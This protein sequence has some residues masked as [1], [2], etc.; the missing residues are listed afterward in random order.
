MI[1]GTI[2]RTNTNMK[3]S[4]K[5]IQHLYL[6]AGFGETPAYIRSK[7]TSDIGSLVDEL[8][9][10]SEKSVPLDFLPKPK[11][12]RKGEV[13]PLQIVALILRSQKENE[14]LNIAWLSRMTL[15]KGRLREKMTFFWQDHFACSAPFS[16][17]MQVQNNMLRE[18]AL[19]SFRKMLHAIARDPAM[20]IY[21]N[22]QQNKKARPNENFAREV[23]ELFTL[24]I[25]HYTE[26]D[27]KEAA[28]AFT[29]WSV[30]RSGNYKFE[31]NEH[32]D[33]EKTVFGKKG[34]FNGG[35]II[36]MLLEQKQ[37]ARYI[38]RKIYREFVSEFVNED[39]VEEMTRIF[40]ESDYNI[41]K[42]M[43]H[44]FTSEW[45]YADENIGCK[46]ASPVELIVRLVRL[47]ELEFTDE[48]SQ[49]E[50][51][52]VLGQTLFFPPNVAGWKGGRNWIDSSSLII[53]LSIPKAMI[54]GSA[55]NLN[56]KP[57]FEEL[58]EKKNKE[59]KVRA[60]WKKIVDQ[61]AV[62]PD[63][64]LEEELTA[65]LIQSPA[66]RIDRELL[67]S[68]VDKSTRNKRVVSTA[69]ALMSMPEFQLI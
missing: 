30:D 9:L 12:N 29:G 66:G 46:I 55:L 41:G 56:A 17:L 37:T 50:L 4:R 20:I 19:G 36:D 7:M 47:T 63:E 60:N 2:Q 11:T 69:A 43:R 15:R 40:Y 61:L 27:I 67:R 32:D 45:F 13:R 38:C 48:K 62:V 16:W 65:A 5:K 44:V 26:N 25:G 31:A 53:R 35:D 52:K 42:L 8:F 49:L 59:V 10:E 58:E 33:G 34:N 18:H 23:M 54:D 6:R 1:L 64:D 28:R 24:G 21:L 68:L 51:Q 57:F 3:T 22:N 14:R 39:A